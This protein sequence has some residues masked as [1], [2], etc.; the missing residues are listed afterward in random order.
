[1]SISSRLPPVQLTT[2][3]ALAPNTAASPAQPVQS[4]AP[5]S[6]RQTALAQMI[7]QAL[8]AQDSIVG[9]T[10]ALTAAA[11][12]TAL[13]EPVL[14]AAQQIIAHQLQLNSGKLNGAAVKQAILNSGLFQEAKL[15]AG[16]APSAATDL[17]ATLL[18]LQ[19]V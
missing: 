18:G 13:P 15:A 4:A 14:Q 5:A 16:Q 11:G 17:K 19:K 6:S 10:S 2:G 9:L 1:M 3:K 12:K 7:Q 8:G